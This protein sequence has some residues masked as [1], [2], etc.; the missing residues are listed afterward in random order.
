MC[1]FDAWTSR[2]RKKI[3][4][5]WQGPQMNL[6]NQND[7]KNFQC[8]ASFRWTSF[9]WS[10][11][12]YRSVAASGRASAKSC[13]KDAREATSRRFFGGKLH[14]LY[15]CVF[16]M[17]VYLYLCIYMY[18]VR[19]YVCIYVCIYTSMY[20]SMYICKYAYKY[21]YHMYYLYDTEHGI[22]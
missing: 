8:T 10:L 14:V 15:R 16:C 3:R 4:W 9:V 5:L 13:A 22:L 2:W 12:Q 1:R 17:P 21:V 7:S 18:V 19:M 11:R 20:I 6:R